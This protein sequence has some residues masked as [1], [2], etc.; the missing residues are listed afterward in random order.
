MIQCP[1]K[2]ALVTGAGRGIGSATAL[3]LAKQGV[4]VYINYLSSEIDA[5]KTRDTIHDHGG[6]AELM[7]FDITVPQQCEAAVKSIISQAGTLDI[8][9][10][11]AGLKKDRVL[12]MMKADAWNQ[13]LTTNLTGF[14][15]LTKPVVKLMLKNRYGR[16]VNVASTAGIIGNAGQVNYSASKAG[17]IGAT[18]ALAREVASRNITI[19]A[20]A[21]GFIETDMLNGMHRDEMIKN[22]PAGRLGTPEDVAYTI[23]FLCSD[24]ASYIN[25][26][27]IGING[28][29]I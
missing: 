22:I 18:K 9:I 2:T 10:N 19:N 16:I 20:V 11:N 17:L 5:K 25:G 23:S 7:P 24:M 3:E 13:V 12:A 1:D 8:L 26:Q 4:M 29:M 27:V 28:G 15:N 14:Y 21:P 6:R